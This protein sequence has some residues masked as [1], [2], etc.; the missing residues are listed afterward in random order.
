MRLAEKAKLSGKLITIGQMNAHDRRIV[1][2]ALKDDSGVKTQSVGDGF[3]KKLLIFPR[4]QYPQKKNHKS[5]PQN[6]TE[7]Q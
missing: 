5:S 4:K 7:V 1:H 2:L 6:G 3:L